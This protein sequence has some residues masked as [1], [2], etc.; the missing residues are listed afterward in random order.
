MNDG[1]IP[2][3]ACRGAVFTGA[4]FKLDDRTLTTH[5]GRPARTERYPVQTNKCK[6]ICQ[7]KEH[8]RTGVRTSRIVFRNSLSLNT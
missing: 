8:V 3:F 4:E 2:A 6:R 1:F 7:R 5:D